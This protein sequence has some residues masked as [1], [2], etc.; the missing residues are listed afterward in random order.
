MSN[1]KL[2]AVGIE[3]QYGI[4]ASEITAQSHD[5]LKVNGGRAVQQW[6]NKRIKNE[7]LPTSQCG[8][9]I[10]LSS[11]LDDPETAM[12]VHSYLQLNK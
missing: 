4:K 10:K 9:H 5:F 8:C 1:P 6:A 12:E 2:F 11:V 7:D 3:G